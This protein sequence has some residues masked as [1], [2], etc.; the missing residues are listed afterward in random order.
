VLRTA[1]REIS[2]LDRATLRTLVEHL[3]RPSDDVIGQFE[4]GENLAR[5]AGE[6]LAAAM[7][8]D[9]L[10]GARGA[11]LDPGMLLRAS[12]PDRV[13][14]SVVN[15]SGLSEGAQRQAFVNQLAMAMFAW[16]KKNPAKG[17]LSGLL[18]VDEAKDFVPSGKSVPS[19]ES[20]LRLAAQARKYGLGLI[21][22]SQAPKSID[23]NVVANCATLVIGKQS[24]PA[25]IQA[26]KELL[27]NMGA[28]ASD[29][30]RLKTGTF[31]AAVKDARTPRR[32]ETSLC[33][34]HH[35]PSPPSQEEVVALAKA[36]RKPV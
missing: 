1:I 35:P 31:Y 33:L 11:K 17:D 12:E 36:S 19:G 28:H 7:D 26:A 5:E 10:L 3:L 25:A 24:S 20:L 18:V 21:F 14:V 22:A 32:I 23:H 6:L 13:R 34:T 4:K 9:P 27:A 8:T 15:L 16:V 30:G 2:H 29:V